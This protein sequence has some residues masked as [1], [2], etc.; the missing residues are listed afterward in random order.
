MAL[1]FKKPDGFQSVDGCGYIKSCGFQR[2]NSNL[3]V[4]FII[5]YNKNMKIRK[6]CRSISGSFRRGGRL[7]LVNGKWQDQSKS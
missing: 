6:I 7:M 4:Q 3:K 1:I 5:L 2:E